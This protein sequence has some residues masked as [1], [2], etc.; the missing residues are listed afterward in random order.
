MRLSNL[1]NI[2][3]SAG[4]ETSVFLA[5]SPEVEGVT[6]KY[7]VRKQARASS[8]ASYDL[9]AAERLWKLSEELTGA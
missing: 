9:E 5:S 3:P 6:G 4:A 8:R 2:S 1:I 7:F